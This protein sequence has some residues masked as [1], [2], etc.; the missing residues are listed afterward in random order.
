MQNT[1]P[2]VK[3]EQEAY[4]LLYSDDALTARLFSAIS[5]EAA[6]YQMGWKRYLCNAMNIGKKQIK[7]ITRRDKILNPVERVNRLLHCLEDYVAFE[8]CQ[9]EHSH[10]TK[11]NHALF[12]LPANKSSHNIRRVNELLGKHKKMRLGGACMGFTTAAR[13]GLDS[14]H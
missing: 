2:K 13:G 12:S 11:L 7:A 9:R 1:F 5:N 10:K 8:K 3:T 14:K 6:S 4:A